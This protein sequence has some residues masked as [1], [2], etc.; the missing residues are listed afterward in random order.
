MPL[1]VNVDQW[2]DYDGIDGSGS[3]STFI[4]AS[5][6]LQDQI[7]QLE[8]AQIL[9]YQELLDMDREALAQKLGGYRPEFE[10]ESVVIHPGDKLE[11]I[12]DEIR[13]VHAD[14]EVDTLWQQASGSD[15]TPEELSDEVWQ[16]A[17]EADYKVG[18]ELG[19]SYVDTDGDIMIPDKASNGISVD[20]EGNIV[21][22]DDGV[23]NI[24]DDVPELDQLSN[25]ELNLFLEN[26]EYEKL[27]EILNAA[28]TDRIDH[29]D[30]ILEFWSNRFA[31]RMNP[32]TIR[33]VI[34]NVMPDITEWL[35]NP[36]ITQSAPQ[37][38]FE[39]NRVSI[40]G[41]F[42]FD[43]ETVTEMQNPSSANL[44]AESMTE[45]YENL[46]DRIN[47]VAE[48]NSIDINAYVS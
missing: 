36:D 31:N 42:G 1:V 6:D 24:P 21:G 32:E 11:L 14:G 20:T 19:S 38:M 28:T 47:A 33:N 45:N 2:T 41:L 22:L 15:F 46:L 23:F 12:D 40:F 26:T 25:P 10:H 29:Y 7:R 17:P 9:Q 43:P 44:N 27:E 35:N 8:P 34:Y 30:E 13:L 39:G 16:D 48:E 5:G 18:Q 3:A 4:E 37:V